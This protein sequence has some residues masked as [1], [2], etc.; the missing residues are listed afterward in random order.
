MGSN[1]IFIHCIQTS[2]GATFLEPL[3]TSLY[4]GVIMWKRLASLVVVQ[5]AEWSDIKSK[6]VCLIIMKILSLSVIL[7]MPERRCF[8]LFYFFGCRSHTTNG[9]RKM[10]SFKSWKLDETRQALIIMTV[11]E[12][13]SV[14]CCFLTI[15]TIFLMYVYICS[16]GMSNITPKV[17][18]NYVIFW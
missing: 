18:M 13:R 12:I 15:K 6:V 10:L 16:S 3:C 2:W 14:I 8:D 1:V 7:Q 4:G 5:L 17:I 11:N 9:R